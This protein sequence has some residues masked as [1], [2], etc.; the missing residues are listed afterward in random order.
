MPIETRPQLIFSYVPDTDQQ[1][2][3][4]GPGST[5]E[6]EALALVDG[7]IGTLIAGLQSRNLTGIVNLIVVSDHGK[8]CIVD[9]CRAD[10]QRHDEYRQ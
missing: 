5:E 10:E 4:G 2:H 6:E 1:G 9:N 7:Y 3:L 8:T